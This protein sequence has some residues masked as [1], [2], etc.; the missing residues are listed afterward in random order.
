MPDTNPQTPVQAL[1]KQISTIGN[2]V[3]ASI[4]A[5]YGTKP[6]NLDVN[7]P[8]TTALSLRMPASA[9]PMPS[10]ACKNLDIDFLNSYNDLNVNKNIT[11][12]SL[13]PIVKRLIQ[14]KNSIL[15]SIEGWIASQANDGARQPILAKTIVEWTKKAIGYM[16]C[17]ILIVKQ[18]VTLIQSTVAAITSLINSI[19]Q[20]IASDIAAVA[21]LKNLMNSFS[22]EL[23]KKEGMKLVTIAAIN[24]LQDDIALYNEMGALRKELLS[25][26]AALSKSHLFGQLESS[27]DMFRTLCDAFEH[28]VNNMQRAKGLITNL[29]AAIVS[30]NQS[31]KEVQG[32]DFSIPANPGGVNP[33]ALSNFSVTNYNN[34]FD[35]YDGLTN[36]T[37]LALWDKEL[38]SPSSP[39]LVAHW[40]NIFTSNESGYITFDVNN[41]G[42]FEVG[43]ALNMQE[44]C[45]QASISVRLVI[46][47]GDWIIQTT[48]LGLPAVDGKPQEQD[49][50]S[51]IDYATRDGVFTKVPSAP[52]PYNKLSSG[53]IFKDTVTST[54][55]D[56]IQ[57]ANLLAHLS[58]PPLPANPQYVDPTVL[59]GTTTAPFGSTSDYPS[60]VVEQN[61]LNLTTNPIFILTNDCPIIHYTLT[62]IN[63]IPNVIT[64]APADWEMVASVMKRFPTQEEINLRENSYSTILENLGVNPKL[65]INPYA[66]GSNPLYNP[67]NDPKSTSYDSTNSNSLITS[68]VVSLPST[69]SILNPSIS[70]V[71]DIG[72]ISYAMPQD[73]QLAAA[74]LGKKPY[75]GMQIFT[76]SL[77]F[78]ISRDAPVVTNVPYF[79]EAAISGTTGHMVEFGLQADWGFAPVT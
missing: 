1:D 76:N 8:A 72:T 40:A 78:Q 47:G 55:T 42:V 27:L 53:Y 2:D 46:N 50:S 63:G 45:P 34:L 57:S 21:D 26:K 43:V 28:R 15:R 18:I 14:E 29:E 54:F 4:Q 74:L 77:N 39:N 56:F 67:I 33:G 52:T 12:L 79:T 71:G 41:F 62:T 6:N 69:H 73:N 70:T 25:A 9:I 5:H 68:L 60:P 37:M 32:L 7:A 38:K 22:K 3:V 11:A 66:D 17:G 51:I 20:M 44:I 13:D 75:G 59:V 30:L 65:F 23:L 36:A 31:L 24:F 58:G 48:I 64:I 61:V 10:K 49:N 16:R 19:N 35:T